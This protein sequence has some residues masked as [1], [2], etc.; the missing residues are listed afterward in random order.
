M[1]LQTVT[2][3]TLNEISQEIFTVNRIFKEI[4]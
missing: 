4:C 2:I 1:N 3:W